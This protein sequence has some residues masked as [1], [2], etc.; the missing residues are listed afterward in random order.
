MRKIFYATATYAV[1]VALGA[2]GALQSCTTGESGNN[3]KIDYDAPAAVRIGIVDGTAT[4]GVGDPIT[5]NATTS[6]LTSG[7][8]F[9]Y[10]STT[11][12][13]DKHVGLSESGIDPNETIDDLRANNVVVV[14]VGGNVDRCMIV[15]NDNDLITASMSGHHIDDVKNK[16]VYAKTINN[17]E[18]TIDKVPLTG[19]A[20]LVTVSGSN[21]QGESYT[22]QA[23]MTVTPV[24][25]RLQIGKISA[26][27]YTPGGGG[28]EIEITSF[29]VV[30]VFITNA[31]S[32]MTLAGV[33]AADPQINYKQDTGKYGVPSSGTSGYSVGQPGENLAELPGNSTASGTPLAVLPAT[34][35]TNK[36]WAF[37]LFPEANDV[38]HVVVCLSNIKY[39]VG[40]VE[41]TLAGDKWLTVSK[42]HKNAS[43]GI[44]NGF[45]AGNVYTLGN[46]KFNWSHLTDLPETQSGDVRVFVSIAPW[47]D[48]EIH[49]GN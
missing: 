32:Q 4:R 14:D 48:N 8:I 19:D 47:V 18:G 12:L 43:D 21:N 46:L 26:D 41:R 15:F 16:I 40:T 28:D 45:L 39:K 49:W 6:P 33:L 44:I 29:S 24:A 11:G 20:A 23:E 27:K 25:T 10:S 22:R 1:I 30:G 35:P 13:I 31:Y 37:N 7:H 17:A 36:V 38:P 34:P 9:L 2:L 3:N 42:F 5:G